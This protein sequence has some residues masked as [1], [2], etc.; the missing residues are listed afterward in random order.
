VTRRSSNV[1]QKLSIVLGVRNLVMC[2]GVSIPCV[3]SS[4]FFE[5]GAHVWTQIYD[6]YSITALSLSS[7]TFISSSAILLLH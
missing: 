5:R 6:T 3:A 7:R 2:S 4:A 1:N